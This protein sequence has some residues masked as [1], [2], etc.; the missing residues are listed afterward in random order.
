MI[1][2]HSNATLVKSNQCSFLALEAFYPYLRFHYIVLVEL[3]FFKKRK[4]QRKKKKNKKTKA[5][6]H[7]ESPSKV[8]VSQ[9]TGPEALSF[10]LLLARACYALSS[11]VSSLG[12]SYLS[13]PVLWLQ[14]RPLSSATISSSIWEPAEPVSCL[15]GFLAGLLLLSKCPSYLHLETERLDSQRTAWKPWPGFDPFVDTIYT[16]AN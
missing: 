6:I 5:K 16:A 11:L 2:F 12:P 4:K 14:R 1:A 9:D 15:A 13:F 7:T 3:G 10:F 8:S